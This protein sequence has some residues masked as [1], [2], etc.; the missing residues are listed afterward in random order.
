MNFYCRILIACASLALFTPLLKG[1]DLARS[2]NPLDLSQQQI[3][4]F[5]AQT[6]AGD[7]NACLRLTDYYL[8]ER[9]DPRTAAHWWEVL[10]NLGNDNAIV[11]VGICL[12]YAGDFDAAEKW[13][14]RA[15]EKGDPLADNR[16]Q[17]LA[18]RRDQTK[19]APFIHA[20]TLQLLAPLVFIVFLFTGQF[21]DGRA[22]SRLT[23]D[24]KTLVVDAMS[25]RGEWV[26]LAVLLGVQTLLSYQL[27]D[28]PWL[29]PS[30]FI[31]ILAFFVVSALAAQ[32]RLLRAGLPA[33]YTRSLMLSNF[34]KFAGILVLVSDI[35]IKP[36]S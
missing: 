35:F 22:R 21:L 15:K 7:Y 2:K 8:L 34:V 29:S 19:H 31:V 25:R 26:F 27:G 24:E 36:K 30:F 14:L 18:K 17:D 9:N 23:T 4:E 16:L 5:E 11:E 12:M 20:H 3:A 6:R 28:P 1:D 13:M 32:R 33:G 10:V